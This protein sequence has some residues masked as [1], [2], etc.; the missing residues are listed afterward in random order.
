MASFEGD[1][2]REDVEK[3]SEEIV[4]ARAE[5]KRIEE[6]FEAFTTGFRA[7]QLNREPGALPVPPPSRRVEETRPDVSAAAAV[8]A[9]EPRTPAATPHAVSRK[10]GSRSNAI[11][12]LVAVAIVG[13]ATL[14]ALMLA[15]GGQ[16]PGPDVTAPGTAP[17]AAASTP[18]TAAE[19]PAPVAKPPAPPPVAASGVNVEI[20]T[21]RRVWMRVTLDGKR[22][23]ERE[24]PGDQRIPLHA[25]RS[26][27]IRAGDAG[28][29]AVTQNGR[30]VGSLGADG[31]VATR[32]FTMDAAAR[33]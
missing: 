19:A 28:A 17:A 8:E 30:D 21:R 32:E 29:L 23:F 27:V 13:G 5:R 2:A 6:A 9:S 16:Q 18:Q 31:V 14:G 20:T 24:V 10:P 12:F 4:R 11:L 1:R 25:E 26:I 33:R 3:V 22:A 15:G 7:G